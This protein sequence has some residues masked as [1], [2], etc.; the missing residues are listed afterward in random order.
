MSPKLIREQSVALERRTDEFGQIFH[1]DRTLVQD[2]FVVL[3]EIK[4]VAEGAL[5]FLAQAV[6][7]HAADKVG[8]ELGG[9]LFGA[10]NF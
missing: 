2:G 10:N 1:R 5:H 8:A 6:M 7:G 3:G 9:A 4:F